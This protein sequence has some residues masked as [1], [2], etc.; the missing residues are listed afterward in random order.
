LYLKLLP[1][2]VVISFAAA[3]SPQRSSSLAQAHHSIAAEDWDGMHVQDLNM[4]LRPPPIAPLRLNLPVAPSAAAA[5][6]AA[7]DRRKRK[8]RLDEFVYDDEEETC[9]WL[10]VL[11]K[12][13]LAR[14]S[15]CMVLINR[16][17]QAFS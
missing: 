2:S 14:N 8:N 1:A 7:E 16:W 3:L 9:V 17:F 10:R 6:A 11:M 15:L 12:P 4:P 13:L 5:R